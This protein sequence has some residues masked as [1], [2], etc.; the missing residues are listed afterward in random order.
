MSQVRTES[1]TLRGYSRIRLRQC[2]AIHI[3]IDRGCTAY[4][5][6]VNGIA[7]GNAVRNAEL[8]RPS[9][10]QTHWVIINDDS[11][12][13][14]IVIFKD[15]A[16]LPSAHRRLCK[17]VERLRRG[18]S[19]KDVNGCVLADVEVRKATERFRGE[20]EQRVETI[21]KRISRD[22]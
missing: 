10:L 7:A 20:I 13:N 21:P 9:I 11:S 16:H 18:Q 5:I 8:V 17:A 12:R 1:L 14:P 2:E 22:G 4:V 3:D 15:A 19:I 6:A